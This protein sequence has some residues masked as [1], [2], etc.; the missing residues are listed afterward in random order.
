MACKCVLRCISSILANQESSL[1]IISNKFKRNIHLNSQFKVWKVKIKSLNSTINQAGQSDLKFRLF[2]CPRAVLVERKQ[3]ELRLTNCYLAATETKISWFT[4]ILRSQIIRGF[5]VKLGDP[6]TMF[7][8]LLILL[9]F[10]MMQR[11]QNNFL[12]FQV[13]WRHSLQTQNVG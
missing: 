11:S 12:S 1:N 2:S 3:E 10:S 7:A 5:E 9:Y 6:P 13:Q 8:L 4:S